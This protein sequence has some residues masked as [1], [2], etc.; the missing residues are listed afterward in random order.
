MFVGHN[1]FSY[2]SKK[3][4]FPR[5]VV[6]MLW[7]TE[8]FSLL[9]CATLYFLMFKFCCN[10]VV[11]IYCASLWSNINTKYSSGNHSWPTTRMHNLGGNQHYHHPYFRGSL[12]QATQSAS[13]NAMSA[14]NSSVMKAKPKTLGKNWERTSLFLLVLLR[15]LKLHF[16]IAFQELANTK[17]RE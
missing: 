5:D 12:T 13:F 7:V 15:E 11:V 9:D 4:A 2:K 8:K 16:S 17:N 14:V 1:F 10:V 3:L 6:F